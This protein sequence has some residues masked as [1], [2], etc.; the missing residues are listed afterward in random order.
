[1]IFFLV[2]FFFFFLVDLNLW[3]N[4]RP[5]LRMVFP[6]KDLCLSLLG[7]GGTTW[8]GYF[9]SFSMSPVWFGFPVA[10]MVKNLPETW[11]IWV[12]YPSREDPL[13]KGM[14]I[15]S[16]ILAWRIPRTEEPGGLQSMGSQRVGHTWAINTFHF[17][18]N[19][20]LKFHSPQVTLVS[21]PGL[22]ITS[23]S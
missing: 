1:M 10:Q 18:F 12:W 6:R 9:S 15:H 21:H 11:K 13:E 14:A 5:W 23:R 3:G 19:L 22:P 7:V 2:L 17:Q 16:S 20:G 4:W 8:L